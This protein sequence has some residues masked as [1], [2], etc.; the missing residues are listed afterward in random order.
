VHHSFN[1]RK[2]SNGSLLHKARSH[3]VVD[4]LNTELLKSLKVVLHGF[5]RF[6]GMTLP[7][8]DLAR[9]P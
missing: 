5:E 7:I 1:D 4:C 9:D 8:R 2:T 6:G 3:S